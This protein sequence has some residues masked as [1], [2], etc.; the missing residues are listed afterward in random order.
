MKQAM[1]R[2]RNQLLVLE[3]RFWDVA[4]ALG[5]EADSVG[6]RSG[7][8]A[9]DSCWEV[10]I[11]LLEIECGPLEEINAALERIDLGSFG[12]CHHCGEEI[13]SS[14]LQAMPFARQCLE[15]AQSDLQVEQA[16]TGARIPAPSR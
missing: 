2:F 12:H 13:P 3:A 15:C 6:D 16:A 8:D 14:R 5:D 7:L 1:E 11:G 10:K 4:D 9:D